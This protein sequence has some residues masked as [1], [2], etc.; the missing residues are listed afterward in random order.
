MRGENLQA[1]VLMLLA[2]AVLSVMDATMK[3]LAGHY[4]PLQVAA[5]RGMVS[6]P[7]VI[8]WVYWRERGF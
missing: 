6:L 8:G 2:M 7:F 1:I 5:L 3:Q 4:P